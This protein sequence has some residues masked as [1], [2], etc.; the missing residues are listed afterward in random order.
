MRQLKFRRVLTKCGFAGIVMLLLSSLGDPRCQAQEAGAA[1]AT[2]AQ[3]AVTAPV[4]ARAGDLD[5]SFGVGGHA[6]FGATAVAVQRDG[7]IV[8]AGSEFELARFL[9]NGAFDTSFS[10][11][12][13]VVTDFGVVDDQD[14]ASHA[15][16]VQAD[17]KI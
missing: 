15:V 17:G 7:K 4:R 10:G 13:T 14:V 12:G 1:N 11:D 16:A 6:A 5:L 3:A 9:P 2:T 8:A